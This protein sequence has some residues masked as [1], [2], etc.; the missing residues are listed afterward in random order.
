MST[1]SRQYV[2]ILGVRL[3]RPRW[4][5][6]SQLEDADE[7]AWGLKFDND[8]LDEEFEYDDVYDHFPRP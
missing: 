5:T 3:A 6:S 1:E 7:T 8:G 4:M 2:T